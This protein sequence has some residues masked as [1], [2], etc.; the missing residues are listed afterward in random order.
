MWFPV[1]G[2]DVFLGEKLLSG[3]HEREPASASFRRRGASDSKKHWHNPRS[4]VIFSPE[5]TSRTASRQNPRTGAI[6]SPEGPSRTDS[7][8]EPPYRRRFLAGRPTSYG[9][10]SETLVR[11]S[12]SRQRAYPRSNDVHAPAPASSRRRGAEVRP[13]LQPPIPRP[14]RQSPSPGA[15][16]PTARPR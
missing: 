12:F 15:P 6:F 3:D 16:L 13:P 7:R 11:A 2:S 4:C 5:G 1:D 9:I 8:P 14:A 10:P